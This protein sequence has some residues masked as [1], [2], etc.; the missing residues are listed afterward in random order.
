MD[1]PLLDL[2]TQYQAL[3]PRIRAA[4]DEVLE[5]QQVILG[6]KVAELESKIAEFCGTDFAVGVSSG[7]DALIVALLALDIGPGHEVITTPYS[8]FATAGAVSR[9]GATP[10]FVDIDPVTMNINQDLIEERITPRTKAI[11]PVHLF[12]QCADMD[13]ILE[14]AGA[15][16]LHVIE[17][18]AQAIGALYHGRKAGSMGSIGC[19]SF[20]VSKNLGAYGEGG[21]VV[22]GDPQLHE[23]MKMLR[24]HGENKR[25]FN[26][27]IGGNYRLD[28][29]QA[30]I[31]LVKLEYLDE[32]TE[33]R[34][35]NA[36]TYN[37]LLADTPVV[38]PLEKD[39]N[40]MIYNQY[41][42]RTE[43]RDD[44][45]AFLRSCG[46]ATKIYYPVPIALQNC[47]R[48][49]GYVESSMPNSVAAAADS[50]ALPIYPE[51]SPDQ[52]AY[53]AEKISAF[54]SS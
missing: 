35:K 26:D 7:T 31:L 5:S 34:R 4:I 52:M 36:A 25:Y 15:H 47:Y 14:I 40:F 37:R 38:T 3:K 50:L 42:I 22:T 29:I 43:R 30:A 1:V 51:L 11:L 18:A 24:V 27:F 32:W 17:D 16:G 46:I 48:H 45:M 19:F 13:A 10:V 44:L 28:A 39:G 12:G 2:K 20:Y 54:F 49:L 6:P 23:K 33:K 8:F 41:V 9:V 21:M 53:V